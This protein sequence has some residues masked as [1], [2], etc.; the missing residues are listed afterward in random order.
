MERMP[1]RRTTSSRE[2]YLTAAFGRERWIAKRYNLPLE[3]VKYALREM[4][5]CEF[6]GSAEITADMWKDWPPPPDEPSAKHRMQPSRGAQPGRVVRTQDFSSR[7]LNSDDPRIKAAVDRILDIAAKRAKVAPK[8]C[9]FCG[10]NAKSAGTMLESDDWQ[11]PDR[12]VRICGDC[13]I[14][15][16][17]LVNYDDELHTVR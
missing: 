12:L 8:C 3:R 2:V 17:L 9:S 14:A 6:A 10:R 4:E 5:L 11:S 15:A 13:A 16:T 1:R 7:L